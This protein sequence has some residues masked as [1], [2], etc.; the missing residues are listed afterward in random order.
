MFAVVAVIL[1][2]FGCVFYFM[3]N[4]DY[5]GA[6]FLSGLLW[7]LAMVFAI[8]WVAAPQLERMGWQRVRGTMLIGLIVV[9]ALYAIRPR[10]GAIAALVLVAGSAAAT[11]AGWVRRLSKP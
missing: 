6:Q 8:G 9:L 5:G 7:K 1:A 4:L 10:I 2:A 11:V 3:P